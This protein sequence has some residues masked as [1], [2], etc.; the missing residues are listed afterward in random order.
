M[1]TNVKHFGNYTQFTRVTKPPR[2]SK[3]GERVALTTV[4]I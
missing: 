1:V 2:F 4:K 3:P